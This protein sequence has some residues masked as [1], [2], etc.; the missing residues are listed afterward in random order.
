MLCT[1]TM[2]AVAEMVASAVAIPLVHIADA[3]AEAVR[4]AGLSKAGLI[5][6]AYTME[7]DFYAGRLR[8]RH[9]LDVVVPAE[10]ERRLVHEVIYDELCVGVIDDASRRAYRSVMSNLVD[11]G[12]EGILFGCTEIGLLVGPEDVDVPIFDTTMLHAPCAVELALEP[13]PEV[14]AN[15]GKRR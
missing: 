4:A 11:G 12:A 5:A 13:E 9:G 10:A 3:T 15:A 6:T 2:H 8:D 14:A 1:N 7:Q